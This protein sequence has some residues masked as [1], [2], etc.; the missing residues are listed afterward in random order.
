VPYWSSHLDAAI[1][2]KIEPYTHDAEDRELTIAE[3]PFG[4]FWLMRRMCR[5]LNTGK[6]RPRN[7][8]ITG[9]HSKLGYQS[10]NACGHSP[11]RSISAPVTSE[12][13][14]I[15][16]DACRVFFRLHHCG[17]DARVVG[18]GERDHG[19]LGMYRLRPEQNGFRLLNAFGAS[20]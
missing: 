2:E 5:W 17:R 15:K 7:T 1:S 19:N 12:R 3:M 20:K 16:L 13:R 4:C 10:P 18:E 11:K 8:T 6:T 9:S 14:Y